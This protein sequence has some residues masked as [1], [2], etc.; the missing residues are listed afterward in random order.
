MSP[1]EILIYS[2][3]ER[4]AAAP[5]VAQIKAAGTA[6]ILLRLNSDGGSVFAGYAIYN[7]LSAH[8]PGVTAQIDGIAASTASW[9]AMTGNP[10]LA[11]ANS[12]LV[13]HNPS[14]QM[15][16]GADQ[17]RSEADTLDKIKASIVA[18]YVRKTGLPADQ[19]AT[20]MDAETWLSAT[21]AKAFGFVDEIIDDTAGV[22]MKFDT[23]H[24]KNTPSNLLHS[25]KRIKDYVNKLTAL[26]VS[27]LKPDAP[28]DEVHTALMNKLDELAGHQDRLAA[29]G[30][31]TNNCYNSLDDLYNERNTLFGAHNAAVVE[32]ANLKK[33]FDAASATAAEAQNKLAEAQTTLTNRAA[34][35]QTA[36]NKLEVSN[37]HVNRLESLCGLQGIDPKNAVKHVD[38][39][40]ASTGKKT[41]SQWTAD[42][43]A[44]KTPEAKNT[45]RLA[46][47][48]A[49]TTKQIA[50]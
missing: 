22:S 1:V 17:L 39:P 2:D 6:P 16:G 29:I 28:E 15:A 32:V 21:E 26:G 3:I 43:Q 36:S 19:L 46:L 40:A 50:K 38:D 27:N 7:A 49:I 24:F 42:M 47:E 11:C 9:L 31:E 18:A 25:M 34:E 23:A 20:M 5:I 10:V 41:L 4:E 45:V 30:K 33:Q 14:I 12:M 8:K 35:L 48:T 44:A 13:I 37:G